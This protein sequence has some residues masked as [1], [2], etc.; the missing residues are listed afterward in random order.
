M[1]PTGLV[2]GGQA[3]FD[4][5]QRVGD[6]LKRL[7]ASIQWLI[8]DWFAYGEQVWG[9]TYDQ[10]SEAT[11]YEIKTLYDYAY[12]AKNVDFSVRTEK[13]TFGHHKLV[14]RL[15]PE[16]QRRWLEYAAIHQL[17][18]SQLRQAMGANSPTLSEQ[19]EGW[20][21]LLSPEIKRAINQLFSLGRKAGQG[22]RH[23]SEKLLS[24]IEQH[25]KWLD[26][27]ERMVRNQR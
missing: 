10:V 4:E 25:R 13:L 5:W 7:D 14:A 20:N 3:T 2:A 21:T 8:G 19:S 1:T 26:A 12:V 23:A 24:Q 18:I 22:D 9:Q 15:E 11:G 6:V 27:L 16:E 17:S